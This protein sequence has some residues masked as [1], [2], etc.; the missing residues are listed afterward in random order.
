M[1]TSTA[2]LAVLLAGASVARATSPPILTSLHVVRALSNADAAQERPVAIQATVTY[3]RSYEHIL[4][5]QDGID[6]IFVNSSDILQIAPGDKVLIE[7]ST[8]TSFRPI[9]VASKITLLGHGTLPLPMPSLFEELASGAHDC[10]LVSVHG[11]VESADVI[12]IAGNLSGR[13]GVL[14]DGLIVWVKVD[15]GDESALNSLLDAEVEVSGVA[16]GIFDGKNQLTGVL[17]HVSSLAGIRSVKRAATTPWSLPFTPMDGILTHFH[18]VDRSERVRV[19]GAFTYYEPGI[20]VVIQEA[21]KSC[22]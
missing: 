1:R 3:Y 17:L 9:L 15:T 5:V 6:A 8:R 2:I 10:Q 22:A 13:L 11:V 21:T 14:V 7:G 12:S 18:V 16:A 20:A 19:H 4:F